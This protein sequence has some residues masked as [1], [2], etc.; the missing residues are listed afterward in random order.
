M[1]IQVPTTAPGMFDGKL[2][3]MGDTYIYKVNKTDSSILEIYLPVC[4]RQPRHGGQ[5]SYTQM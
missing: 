1:L 4:L 5:P 2:V 3:S